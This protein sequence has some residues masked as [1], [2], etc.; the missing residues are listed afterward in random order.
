[1]GEQ[2]FPLLL[3]ICGLNEEL[4]AMVSIA[5]DGRAAFN[6]AG[7]ALGT[8]PLWAFH[9]DADGVVGMNG[10]APQSIRYWLGM[11]RI[12]MMSVW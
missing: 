12:L 2:T 9:G 3:Y 6:A 1:M 8:V 5:G 11:H 4:A 7:C 10:P